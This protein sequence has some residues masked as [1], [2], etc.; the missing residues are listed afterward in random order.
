MA[1]CQGGEAKEGHTHQGTGMGDVLRANLNP[2]KIIQT[3]VKVDDD[4]CYIGS[5]TQNDIYI[6]YNICIYIYT[7]MCIYIYICVCEV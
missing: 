4:E 5:V 2:P 6:L 1:S 7:Y 3:A